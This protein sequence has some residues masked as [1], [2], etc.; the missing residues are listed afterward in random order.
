MNDAK[1]TPDAKLLESVW[2]EARGLVQRLE[3]TSV[4]RL[5][6][7]AGDCT[8]E[9]ERAAGAP[10]APPGAD[11]VQLGGAIAPGAG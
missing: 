6:V 4:E 9:I 2:A 8:I 1:S 11:A 5:S 10:A 7:V 3:G